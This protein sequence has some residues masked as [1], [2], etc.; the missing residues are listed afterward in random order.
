MAEGIV[1]HLYSDTCNVFSAG[2]KPSHV[3]KNAIAVMK[4]I[5][6]DISN[7][8]SKS[9]YD[10]RNKQ[11]DLVITVCD[12][13]KESCP[14]FSGKN[15]KMHWSFE[16]PVGLGLNKFR[17]VRDLIYKKFDSNLEKHIR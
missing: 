16:D 6:I 17:E 3:N 2:T 9:V 13:A 11:F 12:N 8:T 15:I 10:L 4:E 14:V 5:N 1:R 7:H